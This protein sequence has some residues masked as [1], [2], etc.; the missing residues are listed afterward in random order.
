MGIG[1][2]IVILWRDLT[3]RR[4]VSSCSR[5]RAL[6]ASISA[7]R[8]SALDWRTISKRTDNVSQN[9]HLF[10]TQK[11]RDAQKRAYPKLWVQVQET[12]A[13]TITKARHIHINDLAWD[14]TWI[15]PLKKTCSRMP[16]NWTIHILFLYL[17]HSRFHIFSSTLQQWPSKHGHVP[18][19][20][21]R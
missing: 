1:I 2:C 6:L 14:K 19:Q 18:H 7:L 9:Y 10:Y 16:W 11:A 3:R 21:A 12:T 17:R 13:L 15:F 5:R 4:I 8:A 20:S